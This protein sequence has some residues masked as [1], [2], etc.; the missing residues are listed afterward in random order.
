MVT[1]SLGQST[2]FHNLNYAHYL[3]QS[4][5]YPWP[6][7]VAV[8]LL[9]GYC[10]CCLPPLIIHSPYSLTYNYSHT[11]SLHKSGKFYC[12]ILGDKITLLL[13]M[14]ASSFEEEEDFA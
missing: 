14:A 10:Y 13:F 6:S 1:C 2:L 12:S 9:P 4:A 3:P 5:N 8:Q 7:N 11:Y